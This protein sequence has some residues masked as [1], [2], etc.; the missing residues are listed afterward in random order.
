MCEG[1]LSCLS[2]KS[3]FASFLPVQDVAFLLRFLKEWSVL[4]VASRTGLKVSDKAL[5][6]GFIYCYIL[7]WLDWK[8]QKHGRGGTT[9]KTRRL[10]MGIHGKGLRGDSI[11]Y[12]TSTMRG[13]ATILPNSLSVY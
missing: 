1:L 3:L 2:T 13:T 10:A 11:A 7:S 5:G 12:W 4:S 9:A 6:V 8:T